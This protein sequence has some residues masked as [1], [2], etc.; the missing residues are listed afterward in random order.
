MSPTNGLVVFYSEA[1]KKALE[2]T[3]VLLECC[4]T[5]CKYKSHS[6]VRRGMQ[7]KEKKEYINK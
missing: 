3:A 4:G 7:I 6:F 1:I 2:V 5:N